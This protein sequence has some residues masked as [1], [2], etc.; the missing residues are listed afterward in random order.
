MP[1]LS[2]TL[3]IRHRPD[4]IFELI[5]DVGRYPEFIKWIRT[6]RVMNKREA[7]G[8]TL[9]RGEASVGFKG[10]S[11]RFATD[12]V[13]DPAARSIKVELAHGPF[14]RLNNTWDLKADADDNTVIDFFIDYEFRNPVLSLLARANTELAVNKIM[15]A[16]RQEADRRYGGAP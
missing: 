4:Q 1:K 9:F 15:N 2:K 16:F 10:F 12:V 6:M 3:I 14:K 7:D 5:S 8:R 13:A 11:E